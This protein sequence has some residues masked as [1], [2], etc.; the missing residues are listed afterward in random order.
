MSRVVVVVRDERWSR[1]TE[2][3]LCVLNIAASLAGLV[4]QLL[5]H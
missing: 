5:W 3:A 4:V 1:R 2:V